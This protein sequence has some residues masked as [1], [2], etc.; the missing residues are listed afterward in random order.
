M[1]FHLLAGTAQGEVYNER[2]NCVLSEVYRPAAE[3][4][5]SE[6]VGSKYFRLILLINHPSALSPAGAMCARET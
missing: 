1:G 5:R 6:E 2:L 3:V 4:G